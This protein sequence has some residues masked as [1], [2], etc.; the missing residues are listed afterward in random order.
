MGKNNTRAAARKAL[1]ARQQPRELL[2]GD[3][4]LGDLGRKTERL[5]LTFG[6]FGTTLRANPGAGELELSEF[7]MEADTLEIDPKDIGKSVE[8][9]R[10]VRSFLERMIHPDDWPIFLDLAKTNRQGTNDLMEVA[11]AIVDKVTGL[12]SVP[13]VDSGPGTAS[14]KPRSTDGSSSPGSRTQALTR[15]ALSM[16]PASRPDLAH[17]FIQAHE[18]RAAG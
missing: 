16:V 10:I 3:V 4:H 17:A 1:A 11:M 13:S 7:L 6:W 18:A 8:A 5:N 15:Q 9:M 14:T 2:S 12:P